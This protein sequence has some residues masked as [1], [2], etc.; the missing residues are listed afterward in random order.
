MS[1]HRRILLLSAYDAASHQQWRQT[2]CDMFPLWHWT[3]L[4]L[5]ARHFSWRVRGNSMSWAFNHRRELTDNHDLVIATSLTDLA[6]LRGFVPELA[7]I[8]TLL[9]FHENQ[10]AYPVGGQQR[11]SIEPAMVNLYS[12]LCADH[13]AFNSEWNRSSFLAG[14]DALLTKLPDHVPQG[15]VTLLREKSSVLPVPLPDQLFVPL[16]FADKKSRPSSDCLEIVWNHRH[17]YDKG[18]DLLLAIVA[19]LVQRGLRFRLHLLGQRF[20]RRP[21]A[22]EGIESLLLN[23]Y[24]ENK[25]EP[26]I[27][28]FMPDRESYEQ[29]LRQSDLVLST[30]LHDF[31]GLS[32]LEATAL[33]CYPIAPDALAYPEYLPAEA[34]YA[35]NGL[36]LP[37]QAAS[38]ADVICRRAAQA[39]KTGLPAL[40]HPLAALSASNLTTTWQQTML[41]LLKL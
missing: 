29:L 38:A 8:P 9:Y 27:N 37:A 35:V 14:V 24:R 10:F 18:P 13:I 4:S 30:A 15:L 31:Q 19:Q 22:F 23:Y 17:E 20:R 2:L 6:S 3:C 11:H 34:L 32:M 26:G 40:Q 39:D 21:D 33:G 16:P 25:I 1:N 7:Q 28:A 41:S 12:A 36:D 5:P